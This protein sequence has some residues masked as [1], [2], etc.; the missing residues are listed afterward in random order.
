MTNSV[1]SA[2]AKLGIAPEATQAVYTVPSFTVPFAAGTRFGD[3]IVQELDRTARLTDT[4]TQDIQQGPYWSEWT[5]AAEAYA[6]WAGWLCRAMVGP[7][8]FTPGVATT[9]AQPSAPGAQAVYLAASPPANA[10]MQLGTGASTEYAQI[11]TPSGSG[12]YLVPVTSPPAGLRFAHSTGDPAQGQARHVFQQNRTPAT[13]W[14]S[15]S[16]TTDDGVD[17][18]GW[19]YCTLASVRLQ[20]TKDGYARLVSQW[21]GRPPAT[22]STFA[23]SET[24]AQPAG[25]WEWAITTAGG[26][27]T[28]GVSLDLALSRVL[29]VTPACNGYQAAYFIGAGP[30]RAGGQYKAIYDTAADLNLYRQ[31]IQQPAVWTLAQPLLQGGSSIAVTLSLSGWTQGAVSLEETYLT[32]QFRLAGIANTADSPSSGVS[33]VVVLNYWNAQYGP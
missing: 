12:P 29:Q 23:E 13:V 6:D 2:G 19:P 28:R 11:G 25:G 21:N 3:H 26:P 20:V 14:P 4:D 8:Q 1:L 9:F 10:V 33:S 16:L 18:L 5:I 30:M 7:D 24:A 31:A 15:Y 32:A 22:V 27:S 17:V